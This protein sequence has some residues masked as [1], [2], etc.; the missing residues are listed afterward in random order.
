MVAE[1][2]RAFPL[3]TGGVL[4]GYFVELGREVVVTH[5]VGPGPDAI[6]RR[7]GFLPDSGFHDE[8]IADLYR[9]SGRRIVY[10]PR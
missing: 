9:A 2:D 5:A 8:T 10:L 6:H 3:E 4:L 7:D 1:A